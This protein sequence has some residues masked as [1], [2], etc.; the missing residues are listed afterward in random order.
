[1]GKQPGGVQKSPPGYLT[2]QKENLSLAIQIRKTSRTRCVPPCS[3]YILG[4]IGLG[5]IESEE[6]DTTLPRSAARRSRLQVASLCIIS[7]QWHR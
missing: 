3:P 7:T 4:P 2:E 1:M 5:I 6:L